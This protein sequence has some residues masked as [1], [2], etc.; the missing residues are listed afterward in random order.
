MDFELTQLGT[1][2]LINL[3]LAVDEPWEY[4]YIPVLQRRGT[5]DVLLAA[6]KLCLSSEIAARK[7]GVDILGQLGSP[8]KTFPDRCLDVLLD[9][10]ATESNEEVLCAIGVACG[11]LQDSRAIYLLTKFKNHP[12]ADV[13]YGVVFGLLTQENPLAI[14]TLIELSADEDTDVR[15]WATFGIG[16]QIDVDTPEIRSALWQRLVQD[17]TEENYETYGEALV[18][19]AKRKDMRI[20]SFLLKELENDAV[21]EK[22]V[23]AAE[24]L[25]DA[26]LYPALIK[27]RDWWDVSPYLLADAIANCNPS[28]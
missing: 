4:E 27:L 15:N 11:H 13:R 23:E 14:K 28:R 10:L 19:L 2:E 3:A 17:N 16:I 7:L 22:A 9:L 26:R 25:G 5:E 20:I 18:G 8:E 24:E 6:Q 21:G 1:D 12:N